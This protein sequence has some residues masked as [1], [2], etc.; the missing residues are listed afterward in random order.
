MSQFNTLVSI[1]KMNYNALQSKYEKRFS[2]GL[3]VTTSFTW[4][5]S[6]NTGC[7]SYWE[8][9]NIQN[10]YNLRADRSAADTDVP[11]IPLWQPMF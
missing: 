6:I 10:P 7:A 4:S 8:D 3:S 5:K 1:G 2:G 11:M 9:C